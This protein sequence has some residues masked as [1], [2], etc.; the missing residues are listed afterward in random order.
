MGEGLGQRRQTVRAKLQA[1]D[2]VAGEVCAGCGQ[3]VPFDAATFVEVAGEAS[4]Y[5]PACARASDDWGILSLLWGEAW[6]PE[7]GREGGSAPPVGVSAQARP[8]AGNGTVCS[9]GRSVAPLTHLTA[10]EAPT[11]QG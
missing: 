4:A 6:P 11:C 10:G 2:Q 7:R 8:A 1:R 5:C 3:V 9:V